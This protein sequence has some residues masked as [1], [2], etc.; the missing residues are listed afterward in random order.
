MRRI[1]HAP[2]LMPG[3]TAVAAFFIAAGCLPLLAQTDSTA[4]ERFTVHAQATIVNQYKPGFSAKYSGPNSLV[5]QEEDQ[6]SVTST[7][8]LGARLW[9]GASLYLNPELAG[10]VGLS[11][12]SGVGANTN[13]EIFR[14]GD[15]APQ[16]YLA[17]LFFRQV[18]ALGGDS[19]WQPG[20]QNQLAG[21]MPANY[22]AFTLGKVGMNDYFDDNRFSHD[23]RTQFLD[24]ALMDYGA[25]DY[26][27]NVRGYTPSF[28]A[29]W[30]TPRHELRCALSMVATTANGNIMNTDIANANSSTLEYTRRHKLRGLDGAI[31]ILGFYT[32]TDMGN[33]RESL[34]LSPTAPDIT[35]T[36]MYGHTK[37][38]FGISGEQYITP[39]LGCFFRASWND[40]NNET[41]AFTEIDHNLSGGISLAGTKWKRPK[42]TVGAAYIISGLSK[43]HRDYLQAGGLGFVL[44]DGNL[45]YGHEQ[46]LGTYYS[47]AIA[48]H[49]FLS[50]YYQFLLNPGY[51]K[52][53]QG[54]VHVFSVRLH[55]E[56]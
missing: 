11:Q 28:I 2:A 16:L 44:G 12:A 15:P 10:G 30:I 55:I 26:P 22:L 20:D 49:I 43:P 5:P 4:N 27:A 48:E 37:Y 1:L 34:A 40:G 31:R 50:G 47:A 36:R 8:Y 13:G 14:V 18:V 32:S 46:V 17:R 42:D 6:T 7:L 33:Y 54:P 21:R 35:A 52:D 38:G 29:E 51:N 3:R 9:R 53:R 25:W 45:D 24:W 23:P 19:T 39:N 41:W 56:V